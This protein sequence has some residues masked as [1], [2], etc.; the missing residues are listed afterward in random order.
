MKVHYSYFKSPAIRKHRAA[1]LS[2][3]VKTMD[4]KC[5]AQPPL[6]L[7]VEDNYALV[8]TA[9]GYM[10]VGVGNTKVFFPTLN[11]EAGLTCSSAGHCAYSFANKRAAAAKKQ[12]TKPLCYAQKLEGAR[13]SV[14]NSKVYQ[15]MVVDR[16]ATGA[17]PAQ[18]LEVAYAVTAAV[19][20]MKG[21]TPYVRVS[22]V[23]DIGP[24]VAAFA[25]T[26]LRTMVDAGLKPYLYTKR[27]PDEQAALAAAGATVLVSDTDFICVSTVE[28]AKTM[29]IPVCPGECGGPIH[30]CFR[31]PLG[32]TTAVVGH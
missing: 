15:A 1:Q 4:A 5:S 6:T 19:L 24:Q 17:S 30:Q 7:V 25:T 3:Y 28:E 12:K 20:S 18:Q 27:G 8:S 23:G 2:K 11:F 31:C 21:R 13:P 22:E 14:F 26:V 9:W 29:G 16:I 10:R 32:K